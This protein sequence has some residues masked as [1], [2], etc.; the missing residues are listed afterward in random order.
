M[1]S[2]IKVLHQLRRRL[3]QSLAT[4]LPS[5]EYQ[6]W[7]ERF[8]RDRLRL[9][10][11]LS[12]VFLCILATLDIML[13]SPAIERNGESAPMLA[14]YGLTFLIYLVVLQFLGLSLNLWLL[15]QVRS[16][17]FTRWAFFGYSGA[18]LV[19]PQL[20]FM[21]V[22]NTMLD[23]GGWAIF[24]LLQAVLIPV[25][26]SWHLISQ[27]SLIGLTSLSFILFRFDFPGLPEG[28]QLPV[29]ILFI[30]AMIC[31]FGVADF[32]V[33]LYERLIIR[34]FD[35]RQQL[36]IFLHAVSHDLRNPVMGTLILLK[37]LPAHDG[38]VWMEQSAINQM[39]TGHEQQLKLINLL[40]ETHSQDTS[41][42]MLHREAISLWKLV[43]T[44]I[45]DWQPMLNQMQ[46][47]V[48]V[49]TVANLPL[50]MVDP[51]HVRR[52]Y[53]NLI[54]N[55]LQHNCPNLNIKFNATVQDNYLHCNV[56][57]DGQG[58]ADLC[59]E[60]VASVPHKHRIFDRYSRGINNRQP[61]HLGLG[62]YISRQIIETHG[63][64]IGV[65][66][67]LDKGTTF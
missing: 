10:N 14:E 45:L 21:I 11:S 42:I 19:L 30:V 48:Q 7:R 32:G 24:F 3:A 61:L 9:V 5:Q 16:P 13:I 23:P 59:V 25:R 8:V 49:L 40:L 67:E 34:E 31:T 12:M 47:T 36:Q 62:L 38:K 6:R 46:G 50:V 22:G 20:Q 54:T 39:I 52:V 1:S 18:V 60:D 51:L 56:S 57:D 65:E 33:F 28:M 43:N 35:L 17:A 44:A 27:A 37:N 4:P 26:W 29:F 64:K 63:G 15:H 41:G 58:I 53:D 66:S 2:L 55:A